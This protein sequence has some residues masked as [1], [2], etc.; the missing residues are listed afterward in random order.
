MTDHLSALEN[1]PPGSYLDPT[2]SRS[3]DPLCGLERQLRR[4][5]LHVTDDDQPE[6][7]EA[8]E[9]L[10]DA[11][12]IDELPSPRELANRLLR[13]TASRAALTA[14]EIEALPADHPRRLAAGIR[15][16]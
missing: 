10:A 12:E 16:Y 13:N 5:G 4:G 9:L 1:V 15:R 8:Q 11:V 7:D 14:D 6:D 3:C 2:R